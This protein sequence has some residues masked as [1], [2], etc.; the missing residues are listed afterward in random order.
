MGRKE[1]THLAGKQPIVF[2]EISVGCNVAGF[3]RSALI[4][5]KTLGRCRRAACREYSSEQQEGHDWSLFDT[6]EQ[7]HGRNPL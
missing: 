5:N 3:Y 1:N 6:A 4:D 2:A 7:F